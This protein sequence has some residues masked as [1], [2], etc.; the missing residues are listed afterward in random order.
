MTITTRLYTFFHGKPVGT[1]AFGN[2]Y[3][4]ERKK[5]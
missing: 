5:S 1:D 4:M 2:R 3:F